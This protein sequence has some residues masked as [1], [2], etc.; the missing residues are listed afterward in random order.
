MLHCG[1]HNVRLKEVR[2]R[3]W[4]CPEKGCPNRNISFDLFMPLALSGAKRMNDGQIREHFASPAEIR[5]ILT[6]LGRDRRT[7]EIKDYLNDQARLL[8]RLRVDLA[9]HEARVKILSQPARTASAV[10]SF[11]ATLKHLTEEPENRRYHAELRPMFRRFD[12]LADWD[13]N[14]ETWRRDCRVTFNYA[15]LL[16]LPDDEA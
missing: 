3:V 10:R 9:K 8:R 13:D 12:L 14:A 5:N 2:S 4:T 15:R 1:R 7:A 6:A 16:R 11:L